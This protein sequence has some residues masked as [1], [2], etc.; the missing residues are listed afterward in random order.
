MTTLEDILS[1]VS[2]GIDYAQDL[3]GIISTLSPAIAERVVLAEADPTSENVQAVFAA[4]AREGKIPPVDLT[5]H[6]LMIN[7]ERH[8]E[9]TVRGNAAPFVLGGAALL[10][11]ILTKKRR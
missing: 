2:A 1:R 10:F 3:S 7:E 5:A 6:L 11:W 8:P 9:D 4:Y